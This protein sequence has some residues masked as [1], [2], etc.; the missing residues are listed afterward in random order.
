MLLNVQ[1]VGQREGA[2]TYLGI[3]EELLYP[4][5][6]DEADPAHYLNTATGN[7]VCNLHEETAQ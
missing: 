2:H 7:V 5:V 6:L 3:P 1:P 4:R